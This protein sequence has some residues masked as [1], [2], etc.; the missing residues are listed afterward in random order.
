MFPD[1]QK[2]VT[3]TGKVCAAFGLIL[4]AIGCSSDLSLSPDLK[5]SSAAN[6]VSTNTENS[7]GVPATELKFIELP[8]GRK[9]SQTIVGE[10]T[11]VEELV[12]REKGGELKLNYCYQ[13]STINNEVCIKSELEVPP[14]AVS[15]DILMSMS[16]GCDHLMTDVDLVFGPHGTFFERPV[17]LQFE[18]SGLDLSEL[19]GD[20]GFYYNNEEIGLWE[21]I[22]AE[23]EVDIK[24]GKIRVTVELE[25]FSC[26]S[27][28][29][30]PI[31]ARYALA[32]SR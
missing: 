16:L 10:N 13:P 22:D 8:Q 9:G 2:E 18:A 24:K 1:S 7:R 5:T 27:I 19:R 26:Y 23:I 14:Y 17:T 15:S 12:T 11:F 32:I 6:A 30:F 20:I 21:F 31:S 4:L 28:R 25:H 29:C 3:T